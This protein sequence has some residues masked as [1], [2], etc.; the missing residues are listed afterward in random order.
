M[1]D[2]VTISVDG[3]NVQVERGSSVV[4][5]IAL[6][7]ICHPAMALSSTELSSTASFRR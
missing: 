6:N 1:R 2:P 5:A 3:R 4:A 7:T